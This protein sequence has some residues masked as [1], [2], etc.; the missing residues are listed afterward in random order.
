MKDREWEVYE[1]TDRKF[2]LMTNKLVLIRIRH[3]SRPKIEARGLFSH[4]RAGK[5]MVFDTEKEAQ[6][7]ADI[8]NIMSREVA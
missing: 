7:F 3:G 8:M 1:T 2:Y 4:Q 5:I 6:K